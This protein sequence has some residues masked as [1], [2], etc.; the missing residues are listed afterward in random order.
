MRE[1][2]DPLALGP[3]SQCAGLLFNVLLGNVL[4]R[5]VS[6]PKSSINPLLY[7]MCVVF[8]TFRRD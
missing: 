7:M 5:C 3:L 6:V 1:Q 4:Y 8:D 2:L